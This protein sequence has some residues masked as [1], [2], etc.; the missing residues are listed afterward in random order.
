MSERAELLRL[1]DE[2]ELLADRFDGYVRNLT[3]LFDQIKTGS[4]HGERAWTGPAAQRFDHD[5]VRR[6]SDMDRLAEQCRIA[7]RNLKRSALH[8]R[9]QARLFENS[10]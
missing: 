2:K 7:A 8:L 1:A 9:E 3:T 4:V 6:R 10:S 5:V